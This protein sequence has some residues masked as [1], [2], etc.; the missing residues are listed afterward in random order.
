MRAMVSGAEILE[1]QPARN[2]A[3]EDGGHV[4][5]DP[6]EARAMPETGVET[7][8]EAGPEAETVIPVRVNRTD[9]AGDEPSTAAV[10]PLRRYL[11][12][13][14]AKDLL[15]REQEV[16]L[17]KRIEAGRA[18]MLMALYR[19][20][21]TRTVM[22]QWAAALAAGTMPARDIID[23][24]AS[25]GT[26][27]E[28][29]EIE[30]VEEI[31]AGEP[32]SS[33]SHL[34]AELLPHLLT[35]LERA[36][37]VRRGDAQGLATVLGGLVIHPAQIDRLAGQ[38]R[39]INRRIVELEG[40]LSR[41]SEEAGLERR[42]F[43]ETYTKA[44]GPGAWFASAARRRGVGWKAL[45][46]HTGAA[47]VIAEIERLIADTGQELR[48]F[49]AMMIDLQRG[50]REAERSKQEMISANLRLVTWIARRHVNRGLPLM[51]LIQEGNIGLM[52]AVEKFD[53]RRG[54]K[55]STYATWWIRQACT[56]AIVDQGHLIRIPAHMT[57][58]ARRVMRA[59]RHLAGELGREP[60]DA[61]L[62]TRLGT[63][64]AKVRAVLDLV[65]EPVSM[66]APVGE[67]GDAT[68][69]DLIEDK[70]AVLPLDAAAQSELRA[71][72][73][74]A[75]AALTPREADVLRL[76]FGVGSAAE[77]TLEEVGRKY[78]V[79]RERIRQIEAKALKKLGQHRAGRTLASFVER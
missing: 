79:T 18:A 52:R 46:H 7:G 14:A 2:G 61:E 60:T 42:D 30:P 58:E 51:D 78:R 32:S 23:L 13:I 1:R 69:G 37:K 4:K 6:K 72:T 59:Q 38:L 20:P 16:A 40:R 3:P 9:I 56:R 74:Q 8:A 65:R 21:V 77:H 19:S 26:P 15:S 5:E 63:P 68:I 48:D 67:D 53:W 11:H 43:L 12:E 57:D 29:E 49:R 27:A 62:A 66:D 31:E 44:V 47:A 35:A 28:I 33:T 55:F 50:N 54:Y 75:L 25:H 10:D 76:R 71:A 36:A 73:E 64:L 41:I 45:R 34:E 22:K 39:D 70:A 24:S 17:A